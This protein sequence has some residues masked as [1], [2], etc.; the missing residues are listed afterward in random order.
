MGSAVHC[1]NAAKGWRRGVS[2]ISGLTAS[3]ATTSG[4]LKSE[5]GT[6]D[7]L[8]GRPFS[9]AAMH[10][11]LVRL[12]QDSVTFVF[13]LVRMPA[14]AD[15]AASMVAKNRALYERIREAGGVQY[16][17]GALPMSQF[18]ALAAKFED[19][20]DL[21]RAY[22]RLR[23]I[24]S[25]DEVA[26]ARIG[27]RFSDL[28]IAAL[29]ENVREGLDERDLGAIVEAAREQATAL[30]GHAL[31]HG[32]GQGVALRRTHERQGDPGVA[33]GRLDDARSRC[34]AAVAL[35]RLDHGR[36]DP[37]LDA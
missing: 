37:I 36:A 18:K 2:P 11:K 6:A 32:Q 34:Q 20:V 24:K 30:Q 33:G 35:G 4:L 14:D 12:P 16:A 10:T 19:I 25:P 23:L 17:V 26:W 3:V 13:N 21:N 8:A 15:Q 28:S 9:T 7:A 1:R 29:H 31:R 5:I 22:T 27:A